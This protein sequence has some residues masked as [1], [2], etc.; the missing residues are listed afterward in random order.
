MNIADMTSEWG[1]RRI[2]GLQSVGA[3]LPVALPTRK[4]GRPVPWSSVGGESNFQQCSIGR[5][6]ADEG[7]RAVG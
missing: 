2:V 6:M 5:V 1:T 4:A 3:K 7:E